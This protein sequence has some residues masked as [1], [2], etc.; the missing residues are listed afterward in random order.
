MT[1][2]QSFTLWC[3]T[4]NTNGL[5]GLKY[6]NLYCIITR[7]CTIEDYHP[8]VF[9]KTSIPALAS[10]KNA[11]PFAQCDSLSSKSWNLTLLGYN[12]LKI[13]NP[14]NLC[15]YVIKFEIIII[16]KSWY[17]LFFASILL[18]KRGLSR[19]RAQAEAYKLAFLSFIIRA[20]SLRLLEVMTT[21]SL[22]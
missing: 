21:L 5:L 11:P 10:V 4:K 7:L 15:D 1:K 17:F 12:I 19:S 2:L 14:T 6:K 13:K 8:K 20:D 16:I 18:H 9:L 22:A 3:V